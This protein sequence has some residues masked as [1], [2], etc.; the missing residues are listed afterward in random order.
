[1][2]N[3]VVGVDL[4]KI[5][6]KAII[7]LENVGAKVVGLTSDGATTNR[8]LWKELGIS[9]KKEDFKNYFENPFDFNRNIFVFSDTPH[10]M[11]TVRNRLYQKK[12]LRV[13]II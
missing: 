8:T 5:V 6:I 3:N 7:L 1:M 4:A 10:L 11:K 12:Q 2:F 13:C 9:V